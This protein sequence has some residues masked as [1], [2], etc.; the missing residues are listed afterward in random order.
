MVAL[1]RLAIAGLL[2]VA[3]AWNYDPDKAAGIDATV[4][5]LRDHN[6]TWLLILAA[7]G[8][9]AFGVYAL[10]EARYRRV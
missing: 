2:V 6:L 10:F 5:M 7:A 9:M 8:L 1:G 4:K 3:A